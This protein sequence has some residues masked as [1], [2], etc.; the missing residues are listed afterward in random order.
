[1]PRIVP[2]QWVTNEEG[3]TG[4]VRTRT[5]D[6]H[7]YV[8]DLLTGRKFTF[9]GTCAADIAEAETAIRGLHSN[10][11]VLDRTDGLARLLLRAEAQASSRIEGVVIAAHKLL[12]AEAARDLDPA[13]RP[14]ISPGRC[15]PT[16]M[17]W[18][19]RWSWRTASRPSP[20][21]PSFG[22]TRGSCARRT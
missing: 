19:S 16:S 14:T 13:E 6:Y 21:T 1:M 11:V 2:R 8:P 10:A 15:S 20:S 18:T 3:L 7:A 17:R 5:R 12:R 22:S 4:K 9:T